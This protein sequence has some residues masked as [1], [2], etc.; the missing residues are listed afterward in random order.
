[1]TNDKTTQLLV[2]LAQLH[3]S[4]DASV[5]ENFGYSPSGYV[6]FDNMIIRVSELEDA[7]RTHDKDAYLSYSDKYY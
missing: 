4:I 5:E 6:W 7:L 1:M 3:K 2:S